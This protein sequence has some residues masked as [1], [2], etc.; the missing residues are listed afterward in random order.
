MDLAFATDKE[1]FPSEKLTTSCHTSSLSMWRDEL[2]KRT[3]IR[4]ASKLS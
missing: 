3:D 1:D 4:Q 2:E